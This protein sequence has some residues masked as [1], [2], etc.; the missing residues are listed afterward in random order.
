MQCPRDGTVLIAE[1][2]HGI[3]VDHCKACNGRWLDHH[4]L[5]E[6]EATRADGDD[7]RGTDRAL[8]SHGVRHRSRGQ[9]GG[10]VVGGFRRR[11]SGAGQPPLCG[12][13]GQHSPLPGP[14]TDG[15]AGAAAFVV[16]FEFFL[17][18]KRR[19]ESRGIPLIAMKCG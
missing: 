7:R 16:F 13:F 19:G 11:R 6:L 5:D 9:G 15:K 1:Y 18:K 10:V 3:E 17:T 4:E 12:R 8:L 2:V 14:A